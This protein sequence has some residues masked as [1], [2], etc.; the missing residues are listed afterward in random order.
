MSQDPRIR[1]TID[2]LVAGEVPPGPSVDT[3]ARRVRGR[4]RRRAAVAGAACLG[5]A[6][7][8]WVAVTPGDDPGTTVAGGGGSARPLDADELAA[9][10]LET[11]QAPIP[12]DLT[13]LLGD[14]DAVAS[15]SGSGLDERADVCSDVI[16]DALG[17]SASSAEAAA[18]A[19]TSPE[20]E[21]ALADDVVT[22]EEYEAAMARLA[23]C[24]AAVG[25]EITPT[26]SEA[27]GQF[28]YELATEVPGVIDPLIAHD[29]C[30]EWHVAKIEA[31]YVTESTRSV[32]TQAPEIDEVA[33]VLDPIELG[34]DEW[35][36][37]S[38]LP[39][40]LEFDVA[41]DDP[42]SNRWI[43][44]LSVDE[45][46]SLTVLI[47]DEALIEPERFTDEDFV[48]VDDAIWYRHEAWGV[49]RETTVGWVAVQDSIDGEATEIVAA[50]SL[51]VVGGT[52]LPRPPLDLGDDGFVEVTELSDLD[53]ATILSAVTDGRSVATRFGS[54]DA[55]RTGCCP[56]LADDELVVMNVIVPG[57]G[58]DPSIVEGIADPAVATIVVSFADGE[59]V[60]VVPE[61]RSGSF[62]VSFF[63][64]WAPAGPS[65]FLAP[66][67][68][69]VALGRDGLL[70]GEADLERGPVVVRTPVG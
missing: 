17:D 18:E 43:R 5:V 11:L 45:L 22:F 10:C 69:I 67:E 1:R 64:F 68:S 4:A 42:R 35:L 56:R 50:A 3:I 52:E 37:P 62:P 41:V 70:I 53:G 40:G 6:G 47:V 23:A 13:V 15:L 51:A 19:S 25:V 44:F 49:V 38:E 33:S 20:Q 21:L 61:D 8:T 48:V 16:T 14:T 55:P 28:S 32:P 27:A 46:T 65:S 30:Y 57:G 58:T 24:S 59:V 9:F 60:E 29:A 34:P 63:V 36:F 7:L 31:A 39:A 2:E 66:I 12:A 26:Y 54:P